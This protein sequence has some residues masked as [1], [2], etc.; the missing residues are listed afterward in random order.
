M[1][2]CTCEPQVRVDSKDNVQ[3]H[4]CRGVWKQ[5]AFCMDF[6]RVADLVF[7]KIGRNMLKII[8]HL[9]GMIDSD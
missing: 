1:R 8:A 3:R 4:R 2:M 5:S 6:A 9:K 7:W